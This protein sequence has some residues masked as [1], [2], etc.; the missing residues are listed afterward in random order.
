MR[1]KAIFVLLVLVLSLATAVPG[2]ASCTLYANTSAIDY[3]WPYGPGCGSTGPGGNE[4][5]D[6]NQSSG[7]FRV[8]YWSSL[9]DYYCFYYGP[10]VQY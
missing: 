5:V 6:V 9:W 2:G 10:D 3:P 4:C 1:R 8:C 7:S